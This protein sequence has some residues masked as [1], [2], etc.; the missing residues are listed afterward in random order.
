MPLGFF[1]LAQFLALHLAGGGHRKHID[2]VD[3]AWVFVRREAD[4]H[5]HLDLFNQRL[6]WRLAGLQHDERL[7]DRAA[8]RVGLANHRGVRHRAMLHQPALDL[9]WTNA[10][11]RALDDIVRA[12]LVPAIAVD[13]GIAQVYR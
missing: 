11:A 13:S 8:R 6:R 3:L 12:P 7:D 5:V 9:G 2:E 4:A 1:A 10:V